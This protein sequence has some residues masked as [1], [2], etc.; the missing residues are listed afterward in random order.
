MQGLG[1]ANMKLDAIIGM[2]HDGGRNSYILS[3]VAAGSERAGFSGPGSTC[4]LATSPVGSSSSTF[5]DGNTAHSC[6]FGFVFDFYAVQVRDL[7]CV[8]MSKFTAWKIWLYAIYGEILAGSQVIVSDLSVA[9]ARVGVR[10]SLGGN[11]KSSNQIVIQKALFVGRSG[12]ANCLGKVPSLWTC[13][14]YMAYCNHL[15]SAVIHANFRHFIL[16]CSFSNL[17]SWKNDP[18][19]AHVCRTL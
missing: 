13:A 15:T 14:H 5:F 12:N 10:I 4:D 2:F 16:S 18:S 6:L 8:A 7:P 1:L 11:S 9:D 3:N 17:D 19:V